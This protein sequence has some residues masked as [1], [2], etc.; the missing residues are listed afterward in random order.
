M[1]LDDKGARKRLDTITNPVCTSACVISNYPPNSD[2]DN[3]NIKNHSGIV[4]KLKKLILNLP[5]FWDVT[6]RQGVIGQRRF[7][8]SYCSYVQGSV[9]S[10]IFFFSSTL[11]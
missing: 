3:T 5:F 4:T 8:G 2:F 6:L 11:L 7:K 9:G 1:A 10:S